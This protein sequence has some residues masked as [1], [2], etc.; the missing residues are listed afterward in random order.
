[1]SILLKKI[2]KMLKLCYHITSVDEVALFYCGAP[3]FNECCKYDPNWWLFVLQSTLIR[4]FIISYI[5]T[6]LKTTGSDENGYFLLSLIDHSYNWHIH[7]VDS[8]L[9]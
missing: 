1:M 2:H 3:I 6:Q 4:E 7:V 5:N 8:D 9:R